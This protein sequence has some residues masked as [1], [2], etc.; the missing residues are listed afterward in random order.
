[1]SATP[2]V[3][4]AWAGIVQN[5]IWAGIVQNI[6][7][8]GIVQN[9]TWASIVQN[10]TWAGILQNITW[11]GIVQNITLAC[12]LQNITWPGIDR[13][14]Q[15]NMSFTKRDINICIVNC[16]YVYANPNKDDPHEL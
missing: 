1:M 9:I 2:L 6:T 7:W 14:V 12:I 8:A 4:R 16:K 11:A 3:V 13:I 15:N 10:I 5:I